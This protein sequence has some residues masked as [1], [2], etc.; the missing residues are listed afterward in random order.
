MAALTVTSRGQ[1]TLRKDVLKHLGIKPG[2]KIELE[3]MPQGQGL[4][5]AAQSKGKIDDL[6][7]LLAGK[8]KK[9]ASLEEIKQA[10]E[11]AWA[12][13]GKNLDKQDL[14]K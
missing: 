7:G 13:R 8:S 2:D 9:R 11:T 5:K 10:T 12:S 6:I 14:N 3:L 4:L 1:V